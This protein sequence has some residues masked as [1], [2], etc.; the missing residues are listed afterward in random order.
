LTAGIRDQ[1]SEIRDQGEIGHK[2]SETGNLG[3]RIFEEDK[4]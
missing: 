1:R 4:N 2:K 3:I